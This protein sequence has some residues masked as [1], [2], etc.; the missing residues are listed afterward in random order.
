MTKD[1]QRE[2]ILG[3]YPALRLALLLI[4]GI[5]LGYLLSD[6]V[7]YWLIT[8]CIFLLLM[9]PGLS[10]LSHSN[11]RQIL[12]YLI[13]PIAFGGLWFNL[14]NEQ[15]APPEHKLAVFDENLTFY[16]HILDSR[17]TAS[18]HAQ[19]DVKVDSVDIPGAGMWAVA[20][21]SSARMFDKGGVPELNTG[22]YLSFSGT[23]AETPKP[24]NPNDFDYG[25]YLN[26]RGIY[27]V[28]DIEDIIISSPDVSKLQW[29]HWR[30]K[31]LHYVDAIFTESNAALAKAFLL[32]DRDTLNNDQQTAF[33]RAGLAHLMAVSGMHVGFILLPFW[34]IIPYFWTFRYGKI[35][36]LFIALVILIIYSGI[37]GFSTS[38]LRASVMAML[39]VYGKLF[40]KPRNS[41]NILGIA[42]LV[43]LL[44]NPKALFEVGF[45][46]SFTAVFVILVV[47]PVSRSILPPRF[48]Y[49][50]Q[51]KVIQF[52]AISVFVQAGLYPILMHYFNEFSIIG[53][54]S[55]TIAV[56]FAQLMF[57]W[58]IL[59]IPVEL[60]LP[61]WGGWLN[62]PA[63]L[64]AGYLQQ[65]AASASALKWSWIEG[66][67]ASPAF[68]FVWAALFMVIAAA[69][70]PTIRWKAL[71]ILLFTL[72]I[73]QSH[74]LY[75]QNTGNLL[76]TVFDVGHGDAILLETPDGKN[77]LYD[78]GILSFYQNSAE[79]VLLPELKARGIKELDAVILSHPHADHIGGISTLIG[80]IPINMIY[81]SE[82][83]YDS[84]TNQVYLE[85]AQ[86]ADIP[87]ESVGWGDRIRIG[88]AMRFFITGPH[89]DLKGND[90]NTWSVVVK[91]IYGNTAILLSG[92]ADQQSENKMVEH[93]GDF[94]K[95]DLLKVG[96]HASNTSSGSTY[97]NQVNPKYSATS[98]ALQNRYNHPHPQTTQR[99]RQSGTITLYTSL[100]GALT[101]TSNGHT[102]THTTWRNKN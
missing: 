27:S 56:P 67:I 99:L 10:R 9:V 87:I 41:L 78:T 91:A 62:T 15:P 38:I 2:I 90:P 12:A 71:A 72:C 74:L 80:N 32:G 85:K 68:F 40:Q 42:A 51:G 69:L 16:G 6:T 8:F 86:Q 26:N 95:A 83:D 81:N 76:I 57:L 100:N 30:L 22:N 61:G 5:I 43:I 37:T 4:L 94:L 45:Q 17:T 54:L 11:S 49:Q 48:K 34:L 23:L 64:I 65:Y 79:R 29:V 70:K 96:H 36:G 60:V 21:K 66:T 46:L 77:I 58:S 25:A 82:F 31:A 24:R 53:P 39:F 33:S 50:F 13:M 98:L 101:F 7:M 19:L 84:Q 14:H 73:Y 93:Y 75:K 1:L 55:N 59:C 89:P 97:L 20:F 63:D 92:D 3:V 88:D 102:L 52:I 28:I 35:V 47:L 18:G 44:I